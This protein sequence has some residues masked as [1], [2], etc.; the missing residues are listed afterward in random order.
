MG[1]LASTPLVR[2]PYPDHLAMGSDLSE[3]RSPRKR[4]GNSDPAIVV[5]KQNNALLIYALDD[6]AARSGLSIGLPLAN[7]RAICPN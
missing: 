6:P 4:E 5:A 3:R 2:S 1:V 7:A